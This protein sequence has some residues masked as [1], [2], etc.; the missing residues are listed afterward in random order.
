MKAA[1]KVCGD[2]KNLKGKDNTL[3]AESRKFRGKKISRGCK[4]EFQK[5]KL[6][7]SRKKLSPISG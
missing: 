4:N 7:F 5:I 1:Q 2:S 6:N 3:L